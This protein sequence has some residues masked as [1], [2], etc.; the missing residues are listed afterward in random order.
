MFLA[1]QSG[2]FLGALYA[3]VLWFAMLTSAAVALLGLGTASGTIP[4][5]RKMG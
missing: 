3:L 1:R 5:Y 4:Y 2:L